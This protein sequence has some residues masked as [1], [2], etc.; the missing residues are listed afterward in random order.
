MIKR[1]SFTSHFDVYVSRNVTVAYP[2]GFV[3]PVPAD[4]AD[5]ALAAGVATEIDAPA[6]QA[7]TDK[8]AKRKVSAARA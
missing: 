2:A 6:K 8:S 7:E 1:L 5:A 3:G 4:H